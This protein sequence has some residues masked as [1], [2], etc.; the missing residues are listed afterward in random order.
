MVPGRSTQQGDEYAR[1]GLAGIGTPAL[2]AQARTCR[3]GS[4][5][6]DGSFD[7]VA[8]DSVTTAWAAGSSFRTDKPVIARW[9]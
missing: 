3:A 1:Y 4:F 6:V 7:A 2:A 9:N 5:H 8:A